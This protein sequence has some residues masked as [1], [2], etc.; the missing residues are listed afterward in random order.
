[1]HKQCNHYC[2]L[3]RSGNIIEYRKGL[4]AKIGEE[5]VQALENDNQ[6]KKWTAEEARQIKALYRAKAREL[7]KQMKEAA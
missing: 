6:V 5:R 3:K 1:M 4:I 2:N 7:E